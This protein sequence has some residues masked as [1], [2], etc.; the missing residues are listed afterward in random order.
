MLFLSVRIPV[1]DITY[2]WSKRLLLGDSHYVSEIDCIQK[3]LGMFT[4]RTF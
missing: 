3:V 2:I 4:T 1:K